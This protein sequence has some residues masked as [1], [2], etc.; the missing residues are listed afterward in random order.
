MNRFLLL[1]SVLVL[2][3]V[4][5]SLAQDSEESS[6]SERLA[7]ASEYTTIFPVQGDIEKAIE[8]MVL[9]VPVTDR[10]L[11]QSILQRTVKSDRLESVSELALAETFSLEELKALIAF[12]KT[13]HGQSIKQKMPQFQAQIQPVLEQ[14]LREA[15]EDYQRQK[16]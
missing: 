5:P 12:Y 6:L 1:A 14:M 7:V 10:V 9:Q 11:L 3:Y 4:S 15:L 13:D 2:S 16:R 8:A